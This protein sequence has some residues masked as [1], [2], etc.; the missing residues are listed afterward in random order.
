MWKNRCL[1]VYDFQR[2]LVSVSALPEA[3]AVEW[4][5]SYA[6]LC[7]ENHSDYDTV[8]VCTA[9]IYGTRIYSGWKGTVAAFI[10]GRWIWTLLVYAGDYEV[11]PDGT[12][13]LAAAAENSG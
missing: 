3:A 6:L 4:A 12:S 8:S 5:E 2:I 11:F 1:A 9:D 7:K 10:A 13:V